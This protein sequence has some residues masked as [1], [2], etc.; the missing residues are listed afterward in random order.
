MTERSENS[1]NSS[2]RKKYTLTEE[3]KKILEEMR[4]A[5]KEADLI[6]PE[7]RVYFPPSSKWSDPIG[8][9]KYGGINVEYDDEDQDKEEDSE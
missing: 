1:S 6:P 5:E 9:N 8:L 7:K 4:Q 2:K 3:E